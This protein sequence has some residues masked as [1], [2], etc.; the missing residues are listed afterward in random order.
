M[1]R[2][3]QYCAGEILHPNILLGTPGKNVAASPSPE[4]MDWRMHWGHLDL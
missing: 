1:N 3:R 4:A 2:K